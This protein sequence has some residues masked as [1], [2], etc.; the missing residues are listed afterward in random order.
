MFVLWCSC[1]EEVDSLTVNTYIDSH[2]HSIA[3]YCGHRRP[4]KLMS[5]DTRLDV[6]FI[7]QSLSY[8]ASGFHASYK[9]ITGA[10]RVLCV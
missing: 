3:I 9:F 2:P 7:A 8:S 1:A 5:S 6:I 10:M 4:D